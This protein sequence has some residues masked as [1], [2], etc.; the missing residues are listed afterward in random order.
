M[1]HIIMALQSKTL[2]S[3][4]QEFISKL[5]SMRWK[6]RTWQQSHVSGAKRLNKSITLWIHFLPQAR[7]EQPEVQLEEWAYPTI[8]EKTY[9][10]KQPGRACLVL[11]LEVHTI[12]QELLLR[13]FQWTGFGHAVN[14]KH[15][16]AEPEVY[17]YFPVFIIR[18]IMKPNSLMPLGLTYCT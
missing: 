8:T 7:L 3:F 5:K 2:D 1:I 16:R 4:S 15:L 12:F 18:K 13:N 14:E 11:F 6:K 10:D 17:L 9:K